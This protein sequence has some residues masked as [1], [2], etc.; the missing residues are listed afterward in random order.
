M[1][2]I[3]CDS[4][5]CRLR[6]WLSKLKEKRSRSSALSNLYRQEGNA[7]YREVLQPRDLAADYFTKAIFSAP[8]N[9]IELALAHANRAACSKYQ[10]VPGK[11]IVPEVLNDQHIFIEDDFN[12]QLLIFWSYFPI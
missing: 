10:M 5:R 2:Q 7:F 1:I 9:S 8:K 12:V 4:F 11:L 6:Q 3:E